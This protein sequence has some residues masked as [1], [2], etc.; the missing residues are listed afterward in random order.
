MFLLGLS[1]LLLPS[2]AQAYLDP[3][4]GS[5]VLQLLLGTL[6]GGLFALGLFWRRVLA[7]IK[8]LFRRGKP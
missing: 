4:T 8:R 6:L 3:G 2:I 7:F 5:Y 1:L